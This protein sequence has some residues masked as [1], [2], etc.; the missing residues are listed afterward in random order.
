[1]ITYFSWIL[2]KAKKNYCVTRCELLA[3]VQSIKSF[4][5]YLWTK[6]FDMYGS[7]LAQ[8]VNVFKNFKG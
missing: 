5:H 6:V 2:N 1:M 8:M 7:C 4:H 3:I